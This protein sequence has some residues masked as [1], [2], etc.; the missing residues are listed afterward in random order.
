MYATPEIKQTELT[1]KYDQ[2]SFVLLNG[3]MRFL[4]SMTEFLLFSG[5]KKLFSW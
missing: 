4:F 2:K 1:Q 5:K 3:T